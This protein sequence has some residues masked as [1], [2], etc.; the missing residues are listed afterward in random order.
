MD[1]STDLFQLAQPVLDA[2]KGGHWFPAAALLLVLGVAAARKYGAK[3]F[4]ILRS[5]A[6]SV[7]MTFAGAFGASAAAAGLAGASVLG[8]MGAAFGLAVTA[9][10]GY[11][12]LAKFALPLLDKAAQF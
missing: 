7:A 5:D 3:R 4:P 2:I 11:V 9:A 10:G 6:A 1:D 12:M 8:S